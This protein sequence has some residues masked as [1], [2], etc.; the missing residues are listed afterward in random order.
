[1]QKSAFTL[2]EI[3]LVIIFL[4]IFG[5]FSSKLLL[6]IYKDYNHNNQNIQNQLEA[7]TALLQIKRLLENSHLDSLQIL[8]NLQISNIST[9][10]IGKTLIFYEKLEHFTLNGNFAIPCLH[11]VFDP[12]NIQI[13][14]TLTLNFLKLSSNTSCNLKT[15][16]TALLITEDFIA[17]KD[18]YNPDFQ[19]KILALNANSITLEI[20][21]ILIAQPLIK[22]KPQLYFLNSPTLLTFNH[23]V[24]LEKDGNTII[25]T[26]NLSNFSLKAHSLGLE[27]TLCLK[28]AQNT[29]CASSVIVSL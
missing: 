13:K 8:P 15:P 11:G 16:K 27:A 3:L 9:N 23:S 5:I 18:F 14:D 10:L 22:I 7:Q 20:P 4:G 29:H 1:M 2:L 19:G 24:T 28:K 26:K 6:K 21:P 12:K 17:P 25:L